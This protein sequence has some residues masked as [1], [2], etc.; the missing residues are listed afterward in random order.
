MKI[1]GSGRIRLAIDRHLVKPKVGHAR[2]RQF[3][4]LE[5][6]IG[7]LHDDVGYRCLARIRAD[8]TE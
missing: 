1:A 3:I 4:L 5:R 6:Q 8:R 2:Y 7:I